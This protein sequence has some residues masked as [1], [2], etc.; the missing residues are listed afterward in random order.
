M[1]RSNLHHKQ[2]ADPPKVI[3]QSKV[4]HAVTLGREYFWLFPLR[5]PRTPNHTLYTTPLL[6]PHTT[7]LQQLAA[8]KVAKSQ[9]GYFW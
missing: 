4:K 1:K 5:A 3:Q 6:A 7:K 2:T 9:L 8:G